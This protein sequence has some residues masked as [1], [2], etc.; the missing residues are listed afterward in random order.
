MPLATV[1]GGGVFGAVPAESAGVRRPIN[2]PSL[3]SGGKKVVIVTKDSPTKENWV[4]PIDAD[5]PPLKSPTE[6][7]PAYRLQRETSAGGIASSNVEKIV[8]SQA[9]MTSSI[10]TSD[11]PFN[12]RQLLRKTDYAP[13]DT[14]R[15]MKDGN[16]DAGGH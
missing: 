6:N 14:L 8:P 5:S 1:A 12:F 3:G 7:R 11:G 4:S 9:L 16:L 15:K 10:D 2:L 13:T